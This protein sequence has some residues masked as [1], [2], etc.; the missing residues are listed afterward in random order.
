MKFSTREELALPAEDAFAE[1]TNFTRFERQALRRGIE[2]ARQKKILPDGTE[3]IFWQ[4]SFRWRGRE[5]R[6]RADLI[7]CLPPERLLIEAQSGG[8]D[9]DLLVDLT[10]L[11]PDRTRLRVQLELRPQTMAAR[12]LIQ[13]LKLGKPRLMRRFKGRVSRFAREIEERWKESSRPW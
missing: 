13:S 1:L 3:R 8:I 4:A 7:E 5:R 12:F 10:P 6:L 9:S 2:I 11:S